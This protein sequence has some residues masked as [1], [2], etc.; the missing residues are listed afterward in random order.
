MFAE[1]AEKVFNAAAFTLRFKSGAW[2]STLRLMSIRTHF[3]SRMKTHILLISFAL[4][5]AFPSL[6]R[7]DKP[8]VPDE[9]EVKTLTENSLTSFGKGVK[10]KDFSKFYDDI[11]VVWQKQTS[12]EKLK[13]LFKD[14]LDKDVDL[15]AIVKEKEPVFNHPAEIGEND[16]LVIKGYYPTTPHRVIFTLK[17]LQEEDEWKLVG[18]TVDL[19]E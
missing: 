13:E 12:P 3:R 18:I 15:P 8:E 14:F 9:D 6:V 7:A 4:A 10:K 5:V 17:Y 16:V 11:A 1:K 19:A 2:T